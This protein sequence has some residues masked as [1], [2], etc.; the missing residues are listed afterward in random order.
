[1]SNEHFKETITMQVEYF[2][3][4]ALSKKKNPTRRQRP[5]KKQ[6]CRVWGQQSSQVVISNRSARL[7]TAITD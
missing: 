3:A 1:M 5:L 6:R 4:K 2:S 7:Q